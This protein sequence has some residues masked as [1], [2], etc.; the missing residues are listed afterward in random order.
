MSDETTQPADP[1][2]PAP[3]PEPAEGTRDPS[4]LPTRS[5]PLLT[6]SKEFSE[7]GATRNIVTVEVDHE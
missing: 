1:Q 2:Q 6:K 3:A 5:D 4:P 7:D